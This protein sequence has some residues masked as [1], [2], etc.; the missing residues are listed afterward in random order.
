MDNQ[1]LQTPLHIF[2]FNGDGNGDG[3]DGTGAK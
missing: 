1:V 3:G 2:N